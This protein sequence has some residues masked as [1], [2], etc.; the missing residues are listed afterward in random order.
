M[1]TFQMAPGAMVIKGPTHAGLERMT[2]GAG[3]LARMLGGAIRSLD[4]WRE[5]RIA[6]HNDAMLVQLAAHD[7][8]VMAELRAGIDRRDADS[9]V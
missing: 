3:I 1:T 8:R 6:A 2:T 9:G 7:P 4:I 5:A